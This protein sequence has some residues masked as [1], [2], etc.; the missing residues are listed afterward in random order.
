MNYQQAKSDSNGEFLFKDSY[1]EDIEFV[2][3]PSFLEPRD[4]DYGGKTV[5]VSKA[6][7]VCLSQ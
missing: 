1:I 6:G 5:T 7:Y 2:Y 4:W 3:E